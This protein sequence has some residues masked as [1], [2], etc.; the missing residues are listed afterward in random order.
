MCILNPF[1]ENKATALPH[2]EAFQLL[3]LSSDNGLENISV[4]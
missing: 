1:V 2:K 4:P 3:E